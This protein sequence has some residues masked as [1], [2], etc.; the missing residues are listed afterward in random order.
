[1]PFIEANGCRLHY[2][3]DGPETAPVLVLCHSLGT[4]LS[5]WDGQ[6][7][8]LCQDFRVLRYD[9][10]GH[11]ASSVTPGPYSIEL[12]GKDLLGLLDGLGIARAHLC[13]LSMGGCVALWLGIHAG[14]RIERLVLSNTAARIGTPHHEFNAGTLTMPP[15]RP[16]RETTPAMND[17]IHA[18]GRRFRR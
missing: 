14:E 9:G 1:M 4:N 10:R 11:G 2:R 15:P 6:L 8:R 3:F 5:L 18:T 13:G 12:L 7:A 16:M 17:A